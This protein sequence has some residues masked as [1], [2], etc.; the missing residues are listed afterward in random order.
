MFPVYFVDQDPKQTGLPEDEICYL[1]TKKGIFLKKKVGY[2]E[3]IAPVDKISF[4]EEIQ[5]DAKM[6]INPIE[7]EDAVQVFTFFRAVY[8]LYQA[9]SAVLL[10]YNQQTGQ[11]KIESPHQKVS[12][13]GV[14]Y[15]RGSVMVDGYDMVGTI[16]SH[17]NFNAFH[18]G[19][20]QGDEKTFDGLHTTFG[21]VA[22]DQ[23]SISCSIVANG[24]R[25]IVDPKLYIKGLKEV[26]K[27]TYAGSSYQVYD[28]KT[29]Q[30]VEKK[31]QPQFSLRY[32]F[33]LPKSA[34]VYPKTWLKNVEKY[35]ATN[36]QYPNNSKWD[37]R[38]STSQNLKLIGPYESGT[39]PI[40]FP[41]HEKEEDF[42]PCETCVF[43]MHKIEWAIEQFTEEVDEDFEDFDAD[44]YEPIECHMDND[45]GSC[46]IF[47]GEPVER[48]EDG[49]YRHP[50]YGVVDPVELGLI[51][52]EQLIQDQ[53][54]SDDYLNVDSKEP[55]KT[56]E[57][58]DDIPEML[59]DK[60]KS[61]VEKFWRKVTQ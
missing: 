31:S 7:A 29:K 61:W 15:S 50:V 22:D 60:P 38:R 25:V 32:E 26:Q 34:Y 59:K 46:L 10:F 40:S 1:V 12:G 33:D 36:Q 47:E 37:W 58:S 44:D 30:M 27:M 39:K 23:F 53:F 35:A 49:L 55:S 57:V 45:D 48:G 11:Y 14:H 41:D 8:N 13:G 18:S 21:H 56:P 19:T 17:A 2:I 54:E 28:F 20:D 43:K 5:P 9:E 4:L 24:Y 6:D 42:N 3:S 52:P 51:S 16:H